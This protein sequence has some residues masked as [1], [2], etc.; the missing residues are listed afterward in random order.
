V[1][2]RKL[3]EVRRCEEQRLERRLERSDS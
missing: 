3:G 2:K 1:A